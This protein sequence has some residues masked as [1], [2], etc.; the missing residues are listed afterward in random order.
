MFECLSWSKFFILSFFFFFLSC[1]KQRGLGKLGKLIHNGGLILSPNILTNFNSF[2]WSL[3]INCVI[4]MCNNTWQK[5]Y[6]KKKFFYFIL[7][8]NCVI[9]KYYKYQELPLIWVDSVMKFI[10]RNI[11]TI[12]EK[13]VPMIK[14]S[15]I[16][17]P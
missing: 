16:R 3:N 5:K 12:I 8:I 6:Y 10:F 7:N 13:N 1:P 15:Y 4:I 11:I 17:S 9:I 14:I 2:N